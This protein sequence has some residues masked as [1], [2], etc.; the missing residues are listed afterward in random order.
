LRAEDPDVTD[1]QVDAVAINGASA[2][3]REDDHLHVAPGGGRIEQ[4]RPDLSEFALAAGARSLIAEAGSGIADP[5]GQRAGQQ[6][7][8]HHATDRRGHLR[9]ERVLHAL[10]GES[11]HGMANCVTGAHGKE[12]EA[13]EH[14]CADR[15]VPSM[16]EHVLKRTQDP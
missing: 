10:R 8:R 5:T 14:R 3:R 4:L 9:P 6:A 15:R 16:F 13:L 2:L 1:P 12:P 7:R 11:E